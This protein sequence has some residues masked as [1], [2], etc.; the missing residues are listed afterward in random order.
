MVI[1]R[2]HPSSRRAMVM[3]VPYSPSNRLAELADSDRE[4]GEVKWSVGFLSG[5]VKVH[6]GRWQRFKDRFRKRT[7]EENLGIAGADALIHVHA[8]DDATLEIQLHLVNFSDTEQILIESIGADFLSV[9]SAS[10]NPGGAT[11]LPAI[12]PVAARSIAG[13]TVRFQILAP[14]IRAMASHIR[15]IQRRPSSA[16]A[17]VHL[18]G[19]LIASQGPVRAPISFQVDVPTPGI[20]WAASDILPTGQ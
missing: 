20:D 8:A 1:L 13:L 19:T 4:V 10:I 17:H 16:Y 15:D 11:L 3:L 2:D 14:G 7:I 6:E 5:S 18:R 9:A 12:R